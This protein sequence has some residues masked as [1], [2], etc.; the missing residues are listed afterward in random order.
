[1]YLNAIGLLISWLLLFGFSFMLSD[2]KEHQPKQGCVNQIAQPQ[3]KI[4]VPPTQPKIVIMEPRHKPILLKDGEGLPNIKIKIKGQDEPE[5]PEIPEDDLEKKIRTF[6][7][8]RLVS[9]LIRINVAS[10]VGCT[11][12]DER[13]IFQLKL[14]RALYDDDEKLIKLYTEKLQPYLKEGKISG[15]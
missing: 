7:E 9:I 2:I 6:I 13:I 5:F 11:R 8:H 1:M 3:N 12:E 14:M 4:P 10:C 15:K